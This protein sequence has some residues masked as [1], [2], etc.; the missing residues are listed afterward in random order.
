M[1]RDYINV[2]PRKLLIIFPWDLGG[3]SRRA[4]DASMRKRGLDACTAVQQTT[5]RSTCATGTLRSGGRCGLC[6]C[7]RTDGGVSA[8]S[9]CALSSSAAVHGMPSV[10]LATHAL[11]ESYKE[12]ERETA[13]TLTVLEWCCILRM[14][15]LITS[16]C[17]DS[18]SNMQH[19]RYRQGRCS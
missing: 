10:L 18:W 3:C 9:Y 12:K 17:P 4:W 1:C 8:C 16:H 6:V 14:F 7:A 5:R 2:G 15:A 11:V 13:E 19:R